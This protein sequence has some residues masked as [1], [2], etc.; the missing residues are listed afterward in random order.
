M[1]HGTMTA[2]EYRARVRCN[3]CFKWSWVTA[4]EGTDVNSHVCGK[5]GAAD[6]VV[7]KRIE[8]R[9]ERLDGKKCG[10][11]CQSSRSG[12]CECS[13]GGKNHGICA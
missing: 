13:C 7:S 11:A 1:T 6:A 2:T 5:C 9:S 4:P 12:D 10:G 8:I 3:T